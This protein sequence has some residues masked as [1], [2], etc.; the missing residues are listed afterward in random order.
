MLA[1]KHILVTSS[2]C[3]GAEHDV[4]LPGALFHVLRP[5]LMGS[6]LHC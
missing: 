5:R 1:G 4:C 6:S 3:S 2:A